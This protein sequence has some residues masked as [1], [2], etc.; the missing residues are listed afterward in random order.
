MNFWRQS[1]KSSCK[2]LIL[3]GLAIFRWSFGEWRKVFLS[4]LTR[5]WWWRTRATCSFNS[6]L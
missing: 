4:F 6:R 2:F 5:W 3:F 1:G